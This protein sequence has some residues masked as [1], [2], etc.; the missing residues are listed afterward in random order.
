VPAEDAAVRRVAAVVRRAVPTLNATYEI[1]LSILFLDRLGDP[2]DKE[3]IQT[4]AVRLIAGQAATGGWTYT[5]PHVG[6]TTQ[7]EILTALRQRE[8][9]EP[10]TGIPAAR[11]APLAGTPAERKPAAAPLAGTAVRKP[12]PLEGTTT[13]RPSGS[14]SPGSVSELSRPADAKPAPK[15]PVEDKDKPADAEPPPL[16]ARLK[17]LPV[18]QDHE[19]LLSRRSQTVT[20]NSNTQFALLGVWVAQRHD[21]PARRTLALLVRR[22]ETSQNLDG[23]WG[24]RYQYG[25]GEAERPSMTC[26]G[27]LGLAVGHGIARQPRDGTASK[28]IVDARLRN[29][30]TALSKNVGQP[31]GSWRDQ[32][33]E[34]LYFLWSVERVAV[35]YGLPDIGGKDWYRWGVEILIANQQKRGFWTDGGYHKASPAIDTCLALLFLK[36]ANFIADLKARLPFKPAELTQTIMQVPASSGSPGATRNSEKK[37]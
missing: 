31:T 21:V 22:F 29:G 15:P 25:G 5:C 9:R 18:F 33:M 17:A 2:K 14:P 28:P 24:Y 12:P 6:K 7:Q 3:R 13:S 36:R 26:V 20:D 10:L 32:P 19:R 16:P 8:A 35:L 4:L 37:P 30:L 23:S 34:N 11:G 1:A 27:L